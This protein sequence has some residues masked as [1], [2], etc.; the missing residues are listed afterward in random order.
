MEFKDKEEKLKCFRVIDEEGNL[1]ND[2]KY[3]DIPSKDKLLRIYRKMVLN[4]EADKIFNKAQ[5]MNRISFYMTSHGEE[6]SSVGT[7]A[8]LEHRDLIYP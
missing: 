1:V 4:Q 6:A 5:R 3:L 8:A 2:E 7:A